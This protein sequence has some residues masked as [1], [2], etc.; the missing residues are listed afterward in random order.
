MKKFRL[1]V[2]LVALASLWQTNVSAQVGEARNDF[3][4]GVSGGVTL[5]KIS[6]S[7]TI[8][9]SWKQGL[10][11]GLTARYTCERYY[12]VICALQAEVNYAQLGWKELIE[13]STDTYERTVDYVQV[14]LMARLGFGREVRGFNGY[15]ILGPQLG[16]Y[17]SDKAK[18]NEWASD[19]PSRPNGV[20]YQYKLDI[21]NKFD[22]GI[23]AGVGGEISTAIGHFALEGR[24]YFALSNMFKD[25]KQ[26]PFGRSANGAIVAKVS[27]LFDLIKTKGINRK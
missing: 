15:L 9:Q 6:F 24:Y 25:G 1:R 27:Y 19:T 18:Q 13:N 8:K 23:T 26:Y 20:N 16:F 14:P 7:P 2:A 17:L 3:A 4:V 22:Y 5:N 12:G 21:E 11:M 10:T